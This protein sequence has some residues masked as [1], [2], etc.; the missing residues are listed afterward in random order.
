MGR[1]GEGPIR[2]E[3]IDAS[4]EKDARENLYWDPLQRPRLGSILRSVSSFMT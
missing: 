4:L 2:A 3:A 1:L